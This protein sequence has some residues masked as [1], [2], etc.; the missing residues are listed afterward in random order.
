MKEN[1]VNKENRGNKDNTDNSYSHI[2]KYTGIFGGVQGLNILVGVLRNKFA[3]LFLGPAGMGLLSL[4]N[5]TVNLISSATNFGIPTTGVK[6]ITEQERR[7][8]ERSEEER[9]EEERSEEVSDVREEV[10][11]GR[12]EVQH[13]GLEVN[14]H[15]D[16]DANQCFGMNANQCFGMNAN[17]H[18]A[19]NLIRTYSLISASLGLVVTV[20]LGPLL[21]KGTF[22]WGNHILH[23]IL[24]GPTVFFTILAGGEM[25]ILK[26]THQLKALAF[27]STALVIFS[28]LVSVPIYGV[29]GQQGILAV[30]FL[31]AFCQWGLNFRH[32]MRVCPLRYDFSQASLLRGIPLLRMGMAFVLAGFLNSGAEF[33]VRAYLSNTANLELVGLFNAS[34]TIVI[35]YAGMVFSVMESDYYPRLSA[36]PQKGRELNLCVNRQLE[37]NVLLIGPILMAII[38]GLPLVIPLLYDAQF[39]GMLLMTQVAA[40]GMLFKAVYLP[41]EYLPLSRGESRYF[42]AQECFAVLLLLGCQVLGFKWCG[43]LGV[44]HSGLP[45][46]GAEQAGLTGLGAGILM[47]YAIEAMVVI[48]FSR[49][50]YGY[51]L[52]AAAWRHFFCQVFCGGCML[53]LVILLDYHSWAYWGYGILLLLVSS[54]YSLMQIR[55]NLK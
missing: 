28:L 23:Y 4:F 43:S 46:L 55:G 42:L 7:E 36:V 15:A 13:A 1:K 10:L 14:Q 52:S 32:T 21:D 30:L 33:L 26:A 50:H 45:G 54:S 38:L 24:L 20:L 16:M 8:Q 3:A 34:V 48:L 2:L 29:W 47:A 31:L 44:G 19:I 41:I 35:V 12:N 49:W 9:S 18:A 22:S 17:Q 39:M 6:I 40:L 25:A 27:C 5:S 37:M 53:L 51:S 11:E